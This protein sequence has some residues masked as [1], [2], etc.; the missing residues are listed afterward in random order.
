MLFFRRKPKPVL[1]VHIEEGNSFKWGANFKNTARMRVTGT[2]HLISVGDDFT[3]KGT[4]IITGRDNRLL[5][6]SNCDWRGSIT[7]KGNGM[8]ISIGNHSS[9][10]D[11]SLL[12][13]EG[14]DLTIGK[15]CMLSRKIE[16]RTS[17]AHS[18]IDRSTGQRT[19]PAGSVVIGDHVWIGLGS[20]VSK[21]ALVPSDS[22]IG[23]LSFV[24]GR[25]HEEGVILAGVP[26][27]V[28]KTGITWDRKR[29][30]KFSSTEMA[31]WK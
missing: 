23:A 29:K 17:D 27:K 5:I 26:A 6:G 28:V 19:N 4:V 24:S 9:S 13:F 22:I 1:R 20:I 18:V 31:Y 2:G 11:S 10:A 12:A 25:F 3:L 16:V 30:D 21:G 15:W 8:T 7:I 14:C